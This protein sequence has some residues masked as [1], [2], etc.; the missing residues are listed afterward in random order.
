MKV[1]QRTPDLGIGIRLQKLVATAPSL[2]PKGPYWFGWEKSGSDAFVNEVTTIWDTIKNPAYLPGIF[3]AT[4]DNASQVDWQVEYLPKIWFK[5][6]ESHDKEIVAW[7]GS[8]VQIALPK[9]QNKDYVPARIVLPDPLVVEHSSIPLVVYWS[10]S[11][12]PL[13]LII[14]TGN[15]LSVVPYYGSPSGVLTATASVSGNKV[16]VVQLTI[17]RVT[18][19]FV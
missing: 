5:G 15:S 8:T 18:T 19:G 9:I 14:A 4:V 2:P 11:V 17:K 1:V 3:C 16:G 10:G 13:P 7:T 6:Y 12:A